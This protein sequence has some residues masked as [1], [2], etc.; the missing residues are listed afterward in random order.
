MSKNKSRNAGGRTAGKTNSKK[1]THTDSTKSYSKADRDNQSRRGGSAAGNK[2]TALQKSRFPQDQ[3]V[4]YNLPAVQGVLDCKGEKFGFIADA[5]GGGDVYIAGHNLCGARHGDV[6]TA[7]IVGD[8]P[9]QNGTRRRE[10]RITNVVEVNPLNIVATV[11][12]SDNRFYAKP[13]NRHYGEMLELNSLGG[14]SALDK[15][16][17]DVVP[18]P[19]GDR[20]NVLAVLGRFDEIGMD[21]KSVI[22]AHN[23][24]VEFPRDVLEQSDALPD[25]IDDSDS[26]FTRTDFRDDIIF[27]IDGSESKDFDDAV[28]LVRTENG[29]RLG[30]YI[31]D[32][33]EYVTEK[34][35]LD[36]EAYARGTSVYL[37]DR[38]IPMLPEKLSN[39]LCSLNEGADRFVLADIIDLNE[40]GVPVTHK[41]CEGIIKSAAR[42]TYTGVQAILDGDAELARKYE[43]IT[44]TLFLMKEL[45]EKRINIRKSRGAIDFKLTETQIV[46][47]ESG[48]VADI[49]KRP[50]LLSMQIIEEFMILANMTV[51][52][53]FCNRKTPFVYRAHDKPSAEKIQ[54]LNDYFEAVGLSYR[55][56]FNPTPGQIAGILEKLPP[57]LQ[58][59]VSRV[60]LRAMAKATYEPINKGHFGLALDYYSHFTSPIRRYPDL[61]IHRVIKDSLHFGAAHA[62]R[63]RDAVTAASLQSSKTERVAQECERKVDDYKKAEYMSHHIGE[64]YTGII[65]SVTDFGIFVELDNSAEG[66]VR[67]PLLG[68]FA[69]FDQ[70]RMCIVAGSKVYRLGDSV[71][72]VVEHAEGDRVDFS[73][74]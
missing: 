73:L 35:P 5:N 56:P 39:G 7:V 37:A 20:A 4:G 59:S 48:R 52:E 2:N 71:D 64:T 6:V 24:R 13:D 53:E 47:D 30:V 1:T 31:A 36:R 62:K 3:H 26:E 16:I 19:Q 33:A 38:V 70:K 21:V 63:F 43:N 50:T 11:V 51:A 29:Y 22:A 17:I 46:F 9:G 45:A 49:E 27:T 15:V 66:L 44:P 41:I 23:L 14:A 34:S 8:R 69:A 28:S 61:M 55:C 60:T 58:N 32:V 65:S 10:G 18:A 72:I 42:M 54:A 25:C 40:N 57:D 12:F 74:A 68:A 67:M